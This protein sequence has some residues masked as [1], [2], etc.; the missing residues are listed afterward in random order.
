M[1]NHQAEK[2]VPLIKSGNE[3]AFEQLYTLMKKGVFSFLYSMTNNYH[4]AEE[5]MQ[6]TFIRVKQY[7][8]NF[9][10][11]NFV[12]WVLQI[13]KN[14]CLNHLKKESRNVYLPE[15]TARTIV[16]EKSDFTTP[17]LDT[18]K[19]ILPEDEY[20]IVMLFVIGE[21]KHKEIALLL[22]LP[23]GTVTWKYSK[24]IKFVKNYL[25]EIEKEGRN[26][27]F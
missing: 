18:V 24:A 20:K 17:L 6:D 11:K 21:Y 2:L 22:D 4:V 25:K 23:L 1:K 9:Q 14:L 27:K 16:D 19:K 12:A 5:L 13:A 10:D 3:K 26:E 7:I 8:H 15:E